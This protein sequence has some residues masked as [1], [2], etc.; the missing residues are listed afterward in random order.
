MILTFAN[1]GFP[2]GIPVLL[3]RDRALKLAS[4]IRKHAQ[5]GGILVDPLAGKL[6]VPGGVR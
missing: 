4:Q 2:N 5:G 3:Q 1:A 6:I